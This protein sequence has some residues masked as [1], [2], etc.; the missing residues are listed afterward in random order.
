[1]GRGYV[2]NSPQKYTYGGE[3]S[4]DSPVITRAVHNLCRHE[5]LKANTRMRLLERLK[6]KEKDVKK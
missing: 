6:E 1:M 4:T 5:E 2:Y 3:L